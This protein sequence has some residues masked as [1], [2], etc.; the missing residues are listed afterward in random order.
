[1]KEDQYSGVGVGSATVS[2]GSPG[3]GAI[4]AMGGRTNRGLYALPEGYH[5]RAKARAIAGFRKFKSQGE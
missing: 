3:G 1:M 4:H 2:G 5:E